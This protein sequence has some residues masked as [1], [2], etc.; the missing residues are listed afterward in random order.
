MAQGKAGEQRSDTTAISIFQG[1]DM[2]ELESKGFYSC[3]S[4]ELELALSDKFA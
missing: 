1:M 3:R 2:D 4:P